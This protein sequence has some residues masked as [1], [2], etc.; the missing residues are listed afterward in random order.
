MMPTWESV[1]RRVAIAGRVTDALTGL[2][3]ADAKVTISSAAVS[4]ELTA[5]PDGH[6]HA[7]DLPAGMY[8][9]SATLPGMGSR[10]GAAQKQT[11]VAVDG[12]GK[13]V[14]GVADIGLPPTT[15]SGNVTKQNGTPAEM[16]E[17]SIT[18]SGERTFCDS[19]GNYSLSG[20][21]TGNRHVRVAASGYKPSAAD[22]TVNKAGKTEILN[23]VLE[24]L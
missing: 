20:I 24:P 5:S 1:R 16:A 14:I 13:M 7:L 23:I 19:N 2:A 8:T 11:G 22:V 3:L 21:E 15:I 9:V 4:L 10:Y 18:G 17:V 6:Y 12:A